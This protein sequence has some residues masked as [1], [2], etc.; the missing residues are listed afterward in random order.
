MALLEERLKRERLDYNVVNASVSGETSAGGRARIDDTLAR[1]KPAVVVVELGGNDGLRG[2]PVAQMKSNL[3]AIIERSAKS[4][5][6]VLLIGVRM[7]PNYGPDYTAA[8]GSA[9]AEL[10]KRY[11]VTLVPNML[12]GFGERRDMFQPDGIHPTTEAQPEI[13]ERVWPA[14]RPLLSETVK[15]R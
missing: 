6:R 5:A 12:E 4:G 8:F 14:L 2:L 15:K 11:G 7:P 13:L 3:G 9:F 1:H 10:A